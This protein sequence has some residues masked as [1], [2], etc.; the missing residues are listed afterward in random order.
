LLNT[1][2]PD[3]RYAGQFGVE[4]FPALIL[5]HPD[6]TFH[7]TDGPFSKE[8]ILAF[9]SESKPPGLSQKPNPYVRREARFDW[10]SSLR[11][12]GMAAD[13]LNRDILVV[14][15][16]S[17]AGDWPRI[18]QLLSRPEVYRHVGS[19][20]HCRIRFW[21]ETGP[22]GLTPFG[23][24]SL[25]ALVVVRPDGSHEVLEVPGSA[26]AVVRFVASR[27]INAGIDE[28]KSS[29]DAVASPLRHSEEP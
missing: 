9:L 24:L 15:Y 6:G 25:P 27:P 2:E 3:R 7:A 14:Y 28:P 12:A 8:Q 19:M 29:S 26:D 1:Y 10:Y 5:V 22:K 23:S 17:I 13:R 16:R 18:H 11:E 4:R 21:S 20:L